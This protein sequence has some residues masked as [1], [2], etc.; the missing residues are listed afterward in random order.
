MSTTGFGDIDWSGTA[1]LLIDIQE[2]FISGSL[3]V[4][5]AEE[6]FPP[7]ISLLESTSSHDAPPLTFLTQD[8]HPADHV[9]FASSHAGAKPFTTIEVPHPSLADKTMEQVLWPDHCVQSTSGAD[10]DARVLGALQ[11]RGT[12]V[13][14][15]TQKNVDCYSGF[16]WVISLAHFSLCCLLFSQRGHRS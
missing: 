10:I 5:T 8:Y 15:G 11:G 7:L 13:Q 14:K 4:P 6:I 3:A 2:D 1:L 16:A 9:S 12:V